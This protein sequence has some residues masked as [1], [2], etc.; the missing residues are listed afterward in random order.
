MSDTF[1][2]GD[3]VYSADGQLV[4]YVAA[5]P[6]GHVVSDLYGDGEDEPRIVSDSTFITKRVSKEPPVEAKN[7]EIAAL[8]AQIVEKNEAL[9]TLRQ[10]IAAEEKAAKARHA[11][12]A[13][14]SGL[15]TLE[16]F[17]AGRITHLVF[18]DNYNGPT[19]QTFADGMAYVD[20]DRYAKNKINGMKLLTLF[21]DSKGNLTW[22]IYKYRQPSSSTDYEVRPATS[23]EEAVEIARTYWNAEMDDR[24]A[25]GYTPG[26]YWVK[27]G[28]AI[29]FEV[30]ADLAEKMRAI[31]LTNA[32]DHLAKAEAELA[33]RRAALA[34]L[35][36][37]GKATEATA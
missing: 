21:G 6:G 4:S 24:R 27:N 15:K 11:E 12:L 17:I 32:K 1:N 20:D 23:Y 3:E 14:W 19:I 16:D 18:C 34:A 5:C 2:Y 7:A 36:A 31:E 10:T 29:G 9:K 28:T 37:G 33:T 25:K 22:E 8:D 35:E 30:P 26:G 13:K